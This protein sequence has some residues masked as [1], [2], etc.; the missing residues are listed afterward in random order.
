MFNQCRTKEIQKH[1]TRVK[2]KAQKNRRKEKR[3]RRER[4]R[5]LDVHY[6]IVLGLHVF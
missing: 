4:E 1:D 3:M 2:K 6:S 5:E